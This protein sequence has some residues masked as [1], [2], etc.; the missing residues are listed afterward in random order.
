MAYLSDLSDVRCTHKKIFR[1]THGDSHTV[2]MDKEVF[3]KTSLDKTA[4]KLTD[5][6]QAM[7]NYKALYKEIQVYLLQQVIIIIIESLQNIT[8]VKSLRFFFF[9]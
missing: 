1:V 8:I 3:G 2:R 5:D 7:S 9:L 4:R 6:I